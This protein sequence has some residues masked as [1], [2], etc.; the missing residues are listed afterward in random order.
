MTM[1]RYVCGLLS[2]RQHAGCPVCGAGPCA[3]C[4]SDSPAPPADKAAP[5]VVRDV[6]PA[7]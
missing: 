4:K 6:P 5:V 1:Y 2:T 7:R 3:F